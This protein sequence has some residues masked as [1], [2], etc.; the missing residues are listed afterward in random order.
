MAGDEGADVQDVQTVANQIQQGLSESGYP[1]IG[2]LTM[3]LGGDSG[4]CTGTLIAPSF[5]LT[6]AHCAGTNMAFNTGSGPANFV[7]HA[8]DQQIKHPSLDMMI[9]HLA[10]PI[11]DIPV[12]HINTGNL[13]GA[14]TTCTAVGFG[15]YTVGTTTTVGSKRSATEQVTSSDNTWINVKTGTGIVDQGDSG[16]PLLCSNGI[17]GVAKSNNGVWPNI[18]AAAYVTVQL[19]W[20]Q[21]TVGPVYTELGLQNG[22]TN[23]PYG[24]KTAGVALVSNMVQ[25]KGA[26]A[27]GSSAVAFTLPS[28]F[29]PA[30]RVYVPVDLCNAAKGRLVIESTGV[31]SVQSEGP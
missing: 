30:A 18:T 28:D 9:A 7:A 3:T 24:T 27:N 15:K 12:M 6:A 10:S 19:A 22:W 11:V 16:S 23:A 20:I 29:R 14:N 1:A 21:R 26:I 13:P 5:V 8:V 2:W 4:G 17:D 25:L 31:A